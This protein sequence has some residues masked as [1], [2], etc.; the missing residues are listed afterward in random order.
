MSEY[1]HARRELKH[2]L[3]EYIR[4]GVTVRMMDTDGVLLLVEAPS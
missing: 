1:V 4:A 3:R 2:L